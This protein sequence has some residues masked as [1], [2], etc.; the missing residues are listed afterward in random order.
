MRVDIAREVGVAGSY[1]LW[2]KVRDLEQYGP[3]IPASGTSGIDVVEFGS[4]KT[5]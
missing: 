3:D 1:L 5:N 4:V 2:Q